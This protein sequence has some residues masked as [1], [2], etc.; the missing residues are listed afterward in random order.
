MTEVCAH[1]C[2]DSIHPVQRVW[3][4]VPWEEGVDGFLGFLLCVFHGSA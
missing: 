2:P 4:W 1:S 3:V